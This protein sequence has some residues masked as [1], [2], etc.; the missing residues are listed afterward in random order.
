MARPTDAGSFAEAVY[1]QLAPLQGSEVLL[2]YPLLKFIGAIGQGL[3]DE[4]ALAHAPVGGD[5][6]A[7]LTNLDTIPSNALLWLGQF[8]G[9]QVDT[10]LTVDQQKQQIRAEG[11]F[12]R[13]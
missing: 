3:Q 7:N 1:A 13:G 9:V 12:S 5:L 2:D 11:G 8:V 4:D 6:W 10:S